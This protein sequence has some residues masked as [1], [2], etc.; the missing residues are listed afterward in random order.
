[1]KFKEKYLSA[2]WSAK[3]K[4]KEVKF[5]LEETMKAHKGSRVIALLFL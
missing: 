2:S 5:A 3:E 1:V 4:K